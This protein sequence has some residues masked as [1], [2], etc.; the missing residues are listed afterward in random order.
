MLFFE[1]NY[2]VTIIHTIT[3]SL[4]LIWGDKMTKTQIQ[5]VIAKAGGEDHILSFRLSNN[6]EYIIR[7]SKESKE[8]ILFWLE[9]EDEILVIES[10]Q[11]TVHGYQTQVKRFVDFKHISEI[12]T[13]EKD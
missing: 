11:Q 1:N 4:N 7:E 5:S 13:F 12:V 2:T 6:R 8:P 10:R 9:L 3:K